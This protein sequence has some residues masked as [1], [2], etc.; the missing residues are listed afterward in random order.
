MKILVPTNEFKAILSRYSRK[1]ICDEIGI[2][3]QYFSLLQNGQRNT[4][5]SV[6]KCLLSLCFDIT[7]GSEQMKELL[8]KYFIEKE[9]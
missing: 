8:E 6:A 9:K 1:Y 7:I 2:T 3:Q 5:I 4:R